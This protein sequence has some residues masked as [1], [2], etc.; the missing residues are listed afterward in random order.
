MQHK[1]NK[2]KDE[3]ERGESRRKMWRNKSDGAPIG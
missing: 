3:N 2:K 1:E